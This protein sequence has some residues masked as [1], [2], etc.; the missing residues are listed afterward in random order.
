MID[1]PILPTCRRRKGDAQKHRIARIIT[2]AL[3]PSLRKNDAC[4]P[5]DV[6]TCSHRRVREDRGY[7]QD[8]AC[9][10]CQDI[11]ESHDALTLLTTIGE[12]RA[13]GGRTTR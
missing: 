7:R 11:D 12:V 1:I 3:D 4:G 5:G 10:G 6:G 8:Q 2:K 9:A 13:E